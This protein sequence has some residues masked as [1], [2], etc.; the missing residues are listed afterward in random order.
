LQGAAKLKFDIPDISERFM[1]LKEITQQYDFTGKTVVITGATGVIGGEIACALVG[2]GA[3]VAMMDRNL[4]LEEEL[5]KRIE[6]SAGRVIIVYGNALKRPTL[7][8]CAAKILDEFGRIDCLI[9]AAGGNHPDATTGP[10]KPF[11]DLPEKAL[12]FTSDLN[13]LGTIFPCQ[14][15]GKY[16]AEQKEGVILNISSMNAYR[17]LT[18]IPA[19]SA[20][21]AAVTNFTQWLAVHMAQEYSPDIRVNAIAPGFFLTRQNR[22]LL[23]DEKTGELTLRGKSIIEH[24]P[25]GRFGHPEDLLGAVLWLLSPASKFVTG[26]VVPIDGGFSAFS[27]V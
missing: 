19:Y 21:K 1:D 4:K 7:E 9:N 13:L 3:N 23:T 22:F 18:R 5:V 2:C 20:A 15:F 17:P 24:T 25:M 12:Q 14:V 11:F 6:T 10:Q 16:M 8:K 26:V 27:G